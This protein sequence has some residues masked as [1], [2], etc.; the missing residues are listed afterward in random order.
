[1]NNDSLNLQ[2]ESDTT[3]TMQPVHSLLGYAG[4]L[5]F[6]GLAAMQIVGW[7]MA[8][9]LLLSYAALILSFLGG[10]IWTATL[11]YRLH[12]QVAVFSNIMML[13]SWLALAFHAIPGVLT[14]IATL[15]ALL[16]FYEFWKI[17]T[18]Y[19]IGLMKMRLVLTLGAVS[20]LVAASLFA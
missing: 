16:M 17:G 6:I 9:I 14:W 15:L 1:M 19:H 12:W 18:Y 20:S 7:P 13:L 11:V 8:Q 10:T 2:P 3:L 5:P 4:L